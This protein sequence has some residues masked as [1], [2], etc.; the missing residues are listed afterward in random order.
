MS[1]SDYNNFVY[2]LNQLNKNKL[3][4]NSKNKANAI[5]EN[6]ESLLHLEPGTLNFNYNENLNSSG[7]NYKNNKNF[8]NALQKGNINAQ[9]KL[10]KKIYG[11]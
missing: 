10:F 3:N 11:I 8:F 4:N 2:S 9:Y 7:R 6:F 1:N 5:R